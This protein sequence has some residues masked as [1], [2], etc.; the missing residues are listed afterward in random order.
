VYSGEYVTMLRGALAMIEAELQFQF[1][2]I[3]T[4]VALP[5]E[6]DSQRQFLARLKEQYAAA[7][8]IVGDIDTKMSAFERVD[9]IRQTLRTL[10]G[11]HAGK[12]QQRQASEDIGITTQEQRGG[13][14][15]RGNSRAYIGEI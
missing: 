2:R 6:S 10:R 8:A 1:D 11:F 3:E 13:I 4:R 12:V 7:A 15:E 9:E 5:G 14:D